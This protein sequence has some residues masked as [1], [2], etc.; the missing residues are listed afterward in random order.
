MSERASELA[1]IFPCSFV[2]MGHT[3]VPVTKQLAPDAHY[4]NLGSWAEEE[5]DPGE[6]PKKVYRAARTHLVVHDRNGRHQAEL[7]EWTDEGPR[8][9]AA[10][11]G[12]ASEPSEAAAA[13]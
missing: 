5:P 7:R 9:R 10:L 6:D 1:K 12:R 2:V 11:V 3:H 4:V 8:V 13:E